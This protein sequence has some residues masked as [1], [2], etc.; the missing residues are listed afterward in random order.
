MFNEKHQILAIQ[1]GVL[2]NY[3]SKV[4]ELYRCPTG[5]RGEARTYSMPDC[6][7]VKNPVSSVI[8]QIGANESMLVKKMEQLKRPSERIVFI[9]EG[10]AT[11]SVW[12]IFYYQERWWDPVPI[13]HG[14][15]TDFTFGDGHCEYWKWQDPRTREFGLW[16]NSLANPNDA[17]FR[18]ERQRDNKD[19]YRLV[20]AIWGRVGW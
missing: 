18:R 16:A 5:R 14:M 4:L 8:A 17:S 9:D 2:W 13:R 6:Y 19:I 3:T 10:F 20:M 1:R 7:L 12:T 15:G 11:P